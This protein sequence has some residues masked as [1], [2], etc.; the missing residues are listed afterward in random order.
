MEMINIFI[1]LALT[2]GIFLLFINH[3]LT[4]ER[5]QKEIISILKEQDKK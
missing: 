2:F 3:G 1:L 4:M 5:Y